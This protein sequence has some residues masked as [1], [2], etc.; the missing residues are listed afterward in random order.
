M[1]RDSTLH[2][3]NK[4]IKIIYT[5]MIIEN[6]IINSVLIYIPIRL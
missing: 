5:R 2:I 1:N 4:M 6:I 3:K